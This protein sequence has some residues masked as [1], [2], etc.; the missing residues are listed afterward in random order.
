VNNYTVKE[1]LF[2]N[3]AF[4]DLINSELRNN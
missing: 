2:I 4:I 3:A 1:N